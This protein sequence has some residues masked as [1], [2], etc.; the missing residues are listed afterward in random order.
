MKKSISSFVSAIILSGGQGSRLGYQEKGLLAFDG[1]P[2]I[3]RKI[4]QLAPLSTDIIMVTNQ[5]DLYTAEMSLRG[6]STSPITVIQDEQPYRGP[7]MGLYCGLKAAQ[8][9]SCFVTAVDMPFFNEDLFQHMLAYTADYNIVVPEINGKFEPLF[10]FYRKN[11]IPR[12]KSLLT[13]QKQGLYHLI[14]HMECVEAHGHASLQTRLIDYKTIQ[15][16]DPDLKIFTNINT[17]QDLM[18][19]DKTNHK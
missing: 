16:F 4:N 18:I 7:L 11:L 14:R 13:N 9:E 8:N 19:A 2:L 17:H 15:K 12:I 3:Q 10:G 6:V 1:Y 5:P